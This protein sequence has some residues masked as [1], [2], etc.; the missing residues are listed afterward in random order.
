[1]R[2]YLGDKNDYLVTLDPIDGTQF[3]LDG[4]SN[5]QIILSVL[6]LLADNSL[7]FT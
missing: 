2:W 5:Y 1:V 7:F 3:Y 6:K 4:H